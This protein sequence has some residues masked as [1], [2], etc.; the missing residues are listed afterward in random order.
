[1]SEFV[2]YLHEVFESL[3][4][5]A[6]RKMFGGYGVY[7]DGVMFGLVADDT[8]YLKSDENSA[9]EFESRGLHAFE[10]NKNG[11]LM[12]MSYHLAPEEIFEDRDAAATWARRSYEIAYQSKK[13]SIRK[14]KS[15]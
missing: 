9:P 7:F 6:T 14:K 12:K 2:R 11:K 10:Y 3:G 15:S 5:I 1:M 8:L 4:T 13:R